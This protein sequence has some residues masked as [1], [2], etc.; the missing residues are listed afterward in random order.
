MKLSLHEL[1]LKIS[2]L[3]RYGVLLAGFFLFIGWLWMLAQ[4][5]DVIGNFQQYQQVSLMQTI[6]LAWISYDLS[7][8]IA[9]FGLALLVLLP[10]VRVVLTGVLFMV[11][12]DY[13]LGLMA[14]AVFAVLAASFCLGIDL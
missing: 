13:V 1:E 12:R 5:G 11:Q 8:L 2:Y 9:Y 7:T 3:L 6:H 14:F 4:H 10:V